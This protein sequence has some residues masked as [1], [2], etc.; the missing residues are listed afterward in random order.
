[1]AQLLGAEYWPV[2]SKS[3]ENVE[4]FFRRISTLAMETNLANEVKEEIKTAVERQA[5]EYKRF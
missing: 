3:G 1:M 4:A 5:C 2:S